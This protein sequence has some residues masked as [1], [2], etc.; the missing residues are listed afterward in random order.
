MDFIIKTKYK[1]LVN[2]SYL[3]EGM[4]GFNAV[5]DLINGNYKVAALEAGIAF[6]SLLAGNYCFEKF[7]R[8]AIKSA[9][10]NLEQTV[11]R[12]INNSSQ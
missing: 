7:G 11:Q 4:F 3:S 10:N 12:E 2:L 9:Q 6:G 1:L 8:E 5:N